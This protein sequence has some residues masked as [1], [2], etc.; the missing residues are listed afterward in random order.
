MTKVTIQ[1]GPC[2]M[3]TVVEA[4]KIDQSTAKVKI[5]TDCKFYQPLQEEL[6]EVDAYQEIFG[7][8]GEGEVY[9]VCAKYC[10]HPTC[11]VPSGILKAVEAECGLALPTDVTMTF[12]K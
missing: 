1:P 8:F 3:T 6:T 7:K 12:E 10:K 2:K 4:E 5:T 9:T 11:P